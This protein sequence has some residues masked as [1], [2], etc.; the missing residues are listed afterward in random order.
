MLQ[1]TLPLKK[2]HGDLKDLR[3]R[4]IERPYNPNHLTSK[5]P[6]L[7]LCK[8]FSNS[9]IDQDETT[10]PILRS[11]QKIPLAGHV[12]KVFEGFV[13]RYIIRGAMKSM[14]LP[15]AF[16]SIV[17]NGLETT[18]PHNL[19]FRLSLTRFLTSLLEKFKNELDADT[20]SSSQAEALPGTELLDPVVKHL[21]R[22]L[23][24]EPLKTAPELRKKFQEID[25][26]KR[27]GDQVIEERIKTSIIEGTIS[28]SNT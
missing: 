5:T 22:A 28:Y 4:A 14:V 6:L 1:R 12:F 13:N 11:F 10:V 17:S 8:A 23:E 16:E 18:Q 7:E 25:K 3:N 26:G 27:K 19:A 20:P 15:Y 21:M 9:R 2:N 24:L